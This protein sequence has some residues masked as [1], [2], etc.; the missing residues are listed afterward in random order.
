[1]ILLNR[2]SVP[3]VI[4]NYKDNCRCWRQSICF[5]YFVF[6]QHVC[7][8]HSYFN[9]VK[10]FPL[11]GKK[12]ITIYVR[13]LWVQFRH[14]SVICINYYHLIH[15]LSLPIAR[16]IWQLRKKWL[17]KIKWQE[18][19]AN[20]ILRS[21][22]PISIVFTSDRRIINLGKKTLIVNIYF[23]DEFDCFRE[24]LLMKNI[25]LSSIFNIVSKFFLLGKKSA[26]IL[27]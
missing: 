4:F 18:N 21:L 19:V 24:I 10:G 22:W 23:I 17:S 15:S 27:A 13:T 12:S 14:R 8:Y 7:I 1:M 6:D 20:D 16:L 26:I 9:N 2:S 5:E 25:D 3:R 11:G